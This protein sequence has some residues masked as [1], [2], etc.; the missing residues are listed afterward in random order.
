[1]EFSCLFAAGVLGHR[2]GP[3][4]DCVLGQLAGK[5]Q[6]HSGLDFATGDGVLLVVVGQAGGFGGDA[7]KDIIHEGVHDAHGLGG[8]AGIRVH[9]LEHLVNVDRIALLATL[10][11]LLGL[12]P[13]G[14]GLG[15][16][17]LL[18]LLRRYFA[19]HACSSIV[20]NSSQIKAEKSQSVL[21]FAV[22][23][24]FYVG[25][26]DRFAEDHLAMNQ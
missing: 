10:S 14:L 5:V 17:L 23:P 9:L 19:R 21:F 8:D 13:S 22:G 2:L 16:R 4:A 25:L 15:C 11:P 26:G 3:F 7:L 12:A 1:M 20:W 6:P 24:F 18:T